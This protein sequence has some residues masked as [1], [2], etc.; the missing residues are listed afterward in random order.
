MHKTLPNKRLP[1]SYQYSFWL[2]HSDPSYLNNY[3]L[4][5]VITKPGTWKINED[6]KADNDENV[7]F[8]TGPIFQGSLRQM[9]GF[10]HFTHQKSSRHIPIT[11]YIKLIT[12]KK[13]EKS[14]PTECTWLWQL[15]THNTS[16]H[17]SDKNNFRESTWKDSISF[18]LHKPAAHCWMHESVSEKE[19]YPAFL[20]PAD[21]KSCCPTHIHHKIHLF[22]SL[23]RMNRQCTYEHIHLRRKFKWS[24]MCNKAEQNIFNTASSYTQNGL[25][26]SWKFFHNQHTY[27]NKNNTYNTPN[28]Y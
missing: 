1:L 12:T 27:C 7:S 24:D 28:S 3:T 2:I 14:P 10:W 6:L 9:L 21:A 17:Y 16:S 4:L 20:L 15:T 23:P 26:F 13:Q 22:H 11:K 25:F 8:F 19:S 5:F 18:L